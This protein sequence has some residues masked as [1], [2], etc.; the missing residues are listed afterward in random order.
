MNASFPLYWVTCPEAAVFI[1][2]N[3]QVESSSDPVQDVVWVCGVRGLQGHV[4]PSAPTLS[5]QHPPE[6]GKTGCG[7]SLFILGGN[8]HRKIISQGLGLNSK[9]E[10][11]GIGDRVFTT[12]SPSR[13]GSV[14][15]F[16]S[17]VIC[18]AAKPLQARHSEA[19]NSVP[20]GVIHNQWPSP[21]GG[22]C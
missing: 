5:S 3:I 16:I 22:H 6:E 20:V 9:G 4:A 14:P 18:S 1:R 15:D 19:R 21:R 10:G 17:I 11:V 12:P 8:R 2:L 7:V 13:T